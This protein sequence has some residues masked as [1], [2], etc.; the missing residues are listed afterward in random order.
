MTRR[1][2]APRVGPCG[3]KRVGGGLLLRNA[4]ILFRAASSNYVS[5]DF[6]NEIWE[7]LSFLFRQSCI[8]SKSSLISESL[9]F[10]IAR[11]VISPEG[12]VSRQPGIGT[13]ALVPAL[14][15]SLEQEATVPSLPTLAPASFV[16]SGSRAFLR[17][18]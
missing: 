18:A 6:R 3:S 17:D 10:A 8:C 12:A 14:S 11:P 2:I 5:F 13:G 16:P 4:S 9:S 7:R 15:L 1:T